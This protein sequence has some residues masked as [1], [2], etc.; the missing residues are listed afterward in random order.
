[1]KNLTE[2]VFIIDRSGSMHGLETDTIGGFNSMIE[3]QKDNAGDVLV[4]TVLFNDKS[5]VVHDRKSIKDIAPMTRQDY[6][7]CGSTALLDAIGCAIHHIGNIHKYARKE[8]IPDKTLFVIT[9]DGMEN[10]SH[11]FDADKIKYMIN[12][13]KEKYDWE[14][15]FL[16]ANIDAVGTA[17]NFGISEDRAV[18]YH[19]DPVGTRLNY[20]V[21]SETITAFR[22]NRIVEKWKEKIAKDFKGR[23]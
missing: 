19:A 18:N 3:N 12:M 13:Q 9:T 5:I 21:I 22:A 6:A 8:D 11:L 16:G 14:F 2:L 7:P 1:M 23:T 15:I 4:S 20:E 10:S 17:K